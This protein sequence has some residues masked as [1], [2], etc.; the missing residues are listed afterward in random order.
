M[1]PVIRLAISQPGL[2]AEHAA[3]YANLFSEELACGAEGFMRRLRCHL[4]AGAC[5][6]AGATLAGVALMLWGTQA[7][8]RMPRGWLLWVVPA[9]PLLTGAVL[10]W[11]ARARNDPQP[12]SVLREQLS[13]DAELL[14]DVSTP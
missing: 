10:A 2:L 8:G 1:H 14:R 6:S 9:V 13:A 7:D 4:L 12:F 3:A 11:V 5:L